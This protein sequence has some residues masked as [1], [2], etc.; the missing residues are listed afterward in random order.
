MNKIKVEIWSDVVCPFCY[1]GKRK[2][3]IALNS[4]NLQDGV[5]IEWKSF[6]LDPNANPN[7]SM[8]IHQYLANK[9]GKDLTWAKEMYNSVVAQAKLVGLNYN[10]EK[11]TIT[12]TLKAHQLAHLAKS[13]NKG[14]E[15]EEAL[16]KAYFT[17]GKN[18]NKV[19]TLIEIGDEFGLSKDDIIYHLEKETYFSD[20]QKE[21][22]E[23][24]EIGVQGVPFFVFDRKYAISG[25]QDPS[26]FEET[27]KKLM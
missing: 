8:D 7:A 23:A 5:E 10:F 6:Q 3:E 24:Q 9:Y 13:I 1:I 12:N 18:L 14:V 22:R 2:F 27:L 25:A 15:M 16:F 21:I 17:E 4:L 20:V 19:E 11:T 26:V